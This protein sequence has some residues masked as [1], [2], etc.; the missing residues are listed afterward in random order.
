MIARHSPGLVATSWIRERLVADTRRTL[1]V[2]LGLFW[3]L[4][5]ALQ[6]QAFMYGGGFISVLKASAAGQ[7]AWIAGSVDWGANIMHSQQLLLNTAAALTQATIGLGLLRRRS[8]KPALVASFGWSLAVWWFGEGFGM[9]LTP[10][11]SPLAGAP[12]AA[13]LY[14]LIG[15]IVWPGEGPGGLVGV[16]GARLIWGVLWLVL[17]WLWL[18]PAGT[19]ADGVSQAISAAPSGLSWLTDAQRWFA[20][21]TAHNGL[22]I[23]LTLSAVSAAIAVAVM[24]NWHARTFLTLSIVLNLG[25]WVIAQGFGGIFAGGATDPNAG[26]LFVLLACALYALVGLRSDAAGAVRNGEGR[27]SPRSRPA[28]H[29]L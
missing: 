26:P 25:F 24:C 19:G 14:L 13:L 3:L 9:L 8:V 27:R 23:G 4:D 1:Q 17:T 15:L 2:C 6:F 5:G 16:R 21:A 10:A 7:P 28:T 20:T 12:G 11:L 18:Q 29:T 22:P